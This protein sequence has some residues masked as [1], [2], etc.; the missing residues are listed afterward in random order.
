MNMYKFLLKLTL[1]TLGLITPILLT[2]NMTYAAPNCSDP[3]TTKDAVSCG[4]SDSSGVPISK[5][6]T[7]SLSDTIKNGVEVLSVVVGVVAVVMIM[8]AGFR[9]IT[10]GGSSDKITSAKN[11]LMYALIGIII[12]ALAQVVVKFVLHTATTP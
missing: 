11:T 1:A 12:V 5:D 9:Y 7:K 2:A 10:S 3:Q 6:P 4:A 8:I